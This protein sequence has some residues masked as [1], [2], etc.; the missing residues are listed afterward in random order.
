MKFLRT[1]TSFLVLGMALT[2]TAGSIYV[3]VKAASQPADEAAVVP[4]PADAA[5]AAA[6]IADEPQA[7]TIQPLVQEAQ[8]NE[9]TEN[10]VAPATAA[11]ASVNRVHHVQLDGSGSFS[12]RLVAYMADGETVP[13][14]NT[15]VQIFAGGVPAASAV[16]N[17]EGMFTV[18]GLSDGVVALVASGNDALLLF[19]VRLIAGG[20]QQAIPVK[21]SNFLD[22]AMSSAVV[23]GPDLALASQLAFGSLAKDAKFGMS[24]R[25][26]TY[27]PA[28]G[29]PSTVLSA[30]PVR[31]HPDGTVSGIVVDPATGRLA[32]Q[33]KLTVH[34]VRDGA[35][36]T[37]VAVT[38]NGRFTA[39]GL[40]QGVYGVVANG[41]DGVFAMG[42]QLTD[43][44][45]VAEQESRYKL[46]SVV[47]DEQP[48]SDDLVI[49]PI[50]IEEDSEE[51]PPPALFINNDGGG[52]GGGGGGFFPPI[53]WWD[54]KDASPRR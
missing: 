45:A 3:T 35:V 32:T 31:L 13:S 44:V 49:T 36:V 27:S 42:V 50:L 17:A 7:E 40:E 54:D 34:F 14:A 21:Y 28:G 15:A 8:T 37:S 6:A 24:G 25:G 53:F 12:G 5:E 38:G 1:L 48:Q 23:S 43:A 30:H 51:E 29:S 46:A 52:G 41:E 22:L 16:T 47:Y 11:L 4:A 26:V 9:T 2:V 18:S 39:T 33:K 20:G 10:S 19:S